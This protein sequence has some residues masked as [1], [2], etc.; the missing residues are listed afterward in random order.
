MSSAL[1]R[2][3]S[4]F[5]MFAVALDGMRA[6]GEPPGDLLSGQ[7]VGDERQHL[8]LTIGEEGCARA[9]LLTS[10]AAMILR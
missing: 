9:R 1:F 8:A 10:S 5:M 2:S 6:E 4:L 3:P 7:A